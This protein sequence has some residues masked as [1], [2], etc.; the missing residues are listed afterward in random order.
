MEVAAG[1]GA[2]CATHKARARRHGHAE[3][4]GITKAELAP[5]IELVRT[6]I[7]K[8]QANPLW[9]HLD[10]RWADLI[11]RAEA[12]LAAYHAGSP[13]FHH[14]VQAAHEL[15]KLS[16]AVGF[17]TIIV[18]GLAMFLLQG[19]APHRF[20]SDRAFSTQLVR[21]L[22]RLTEVNAGTWFDHRSGR[23]KRTYRELPPRVV[24]V[25]SGWIV[26]VIGATGLRL[27]ELERRDREALQRKQDEFKEAMEA[28]T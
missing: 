26:P 4:D 17:R 5:Y 8:N 23:V 16:Q 2:H 22:C 10:E 27:A 18:A 7:D 11:R 13:S 19:H 12:V 6:R 21:R 3:Q 28:L 9:S 1:F 15:I 14:E 25:L 24:T 20:K